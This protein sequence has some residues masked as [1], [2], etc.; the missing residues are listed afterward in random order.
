MLISWT[1]YPSKRRHRRPD[2]DVK[3]VRLPPRMTYSAPVVGDYRP[4]AGVTGSA[5]SR[6]RLCRSA[7]PPPVQYAD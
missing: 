5:I 1:V 4:V 7:Y 6:S 3:R 2:N